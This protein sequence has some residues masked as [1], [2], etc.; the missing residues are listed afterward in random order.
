[1][2]SAAEDERQE[3]VQLAGL[4]H[5][6]QLEGLKKSA[7]VQTLAQRLLKTNPECFRLY[8]A[9]CESCAIGT[10]HMVTQMAPAVLHRTVPQRLQKLAGLPPDAAELLNRAS[11][12]D[13]SLSEVAES[14]LQ[15]PAEND[16][17][18]FSWRVLGRMLQEVE[19]IQLW[20]RA[21]FMRFQWAVPADDFIEAV[22]G[23]AAGHRY[24]AL[25]DLCSTDANRWQA[26]AEQ[27]TSRLELEEL[28]YPL[29]A[30]FQ[31][32]LGDAWKTH[33]TEQYVAA[34]LRPSLHV[35][36]VHRDLLA[37]MEQENWR[38]PGSLSERLMRVSSAS[39]DAAAA[40]LQQHSNLS[41]EELAALEQKFPHHPQVL[42]LLAGLNA[43]PDVQKRRLREYIKLSPDTWAYRLLAELYRRE[44]N[45][46]QWKAVL[47]ECLDQPEFGLEHAQL[48][49]QIA[50]QYMDQSQY[51]KARP[52]AE[53]A[54]E[55]WAEWAI[56][57]AI[58]CYRG[59]GE[60]ELEGVWRSRI[61]ERY[62]KT[63]HWLDYYVWA[64]RTGSDEA[65][66]LLTIV[67]P[68]MAEAAPRFD[69]ESQYMVGLFYQLSKRPKEALAAYRK[70]ADGHLDARQTAFDCLWMAA[71]AGELKDAATRDQALERVAKLTDP[72][73][74][75]LRRLADW[76]Q[77]SWKLAADARPDLAAARAIAAGA[78]PKDRT[79]IHCFIAR[80]L[81]QR[82]QWDDAV[83]FYQAA[84]ADPISRP[85]ATYAMVCVVLRDH[86]VQPGQNGD[87]PE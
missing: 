19:F 58:R 33:W 81:E 80:A 38:A 40:M 6:F 37:R 72:A 30:A 17:G 74:A 14:L 29:F 59:L 44:G 53:Q 21:S 87:K 78:D 31:K 49:V 9:M 35:D 63:N 85:S 25:V 27:A 68:L 23:V 76:L 70:G 10:L 45:L 47:D 77:E 42:K 57:C 71:L 62:P 20:R 50:D 73:A 84:L 3:Y 1:M 64:R 82:G 61:V 5:F 36:D 2:A 4:L 43:E 41:P 18:E 55:S 46:D 22:E 16:T 65:Q 86:G 26:A 34:E 48:R 28:E 60:D 11:I 24:R 15:T 12:R 83:E 67:D 69:A 79:G 51:G 7:A 66:R 32:A 56:L 52:Y 8:D 39:P 75:S 54:A 13:V